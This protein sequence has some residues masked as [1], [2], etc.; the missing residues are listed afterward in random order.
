MSWNRLARLQINRVQEVPRFG[1]QAT[2]S[3][4][5][6]ISVTRYQIRLLALALVASASLL[7]T[8]AQAAETGLVGH[9]KLRGD[10]LDY[11]GQNNHGVNH[12]VDLIHGAFDGEQAYI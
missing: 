5:K 10:C 7:Q 8:V 4:M 1:K 11:S 12:G 6:M 3:R 2:S 9:W